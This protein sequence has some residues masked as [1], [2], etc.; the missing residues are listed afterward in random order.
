[1]AGGPGCRAHPPTARR[2][3]SG[4]QLMS[5][6]KNNRKKAIAVQGAWTP[7]PLDFLRSAACASLSP[8]ASK[9]LLDVHAQLKPN[10]IGNGDICLAPSVLAA[11][12]WTSRASLRAA[13]QELTTAGLLIM[14]RQGSRLD[15]SLFACTLYPLD[16]DLA[17]ID[18]RPGAYLTSDYMAA[19]PQLGLPPTAEQPVR[20]NRPRKDES[21]APSRTKRSKVVPLRPKTGAVRAA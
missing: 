13:V 21:V 6:F 4:W 18:V 19:N 1:M 14:T 20:W 9:L 15:C 5:H 17:K 16:C 11:R 3:L 8:L 7:I 12:G 10:A 2:A